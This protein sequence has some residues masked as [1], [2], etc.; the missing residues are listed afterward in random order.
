MLDSNNNKH[1]VSF[2]KSI[3][4][5]FKIKLSN[6]VHNI[7]GAPIT[8]SSDQITEIFGNNYPYNTIYFGCFLNLFSTYSGVGT[9]TDT[10]DWSGQSFWIITL[11]MQSGV[12]DSIRIY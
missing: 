10:P 12:I 9:Y 8:K 6:E 4:I 7:F 5:S 3:W 11:D 2:F 1:I